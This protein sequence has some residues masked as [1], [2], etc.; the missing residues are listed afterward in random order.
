YIRQSRAASVA[1]NMTFSVPEVADLRSRL[2]TIGTLGEFSTV[3]FNLVGLL[4]EPRIVKA[5]VVNG[6][7]FE[8]MGLRPVLGRLLNALDDGPKAAPVVVLTY[9]FWNDT[10]K[11]D[12]RVIGKVV[13]LG[14]GPATIVGVLEPSVPYPTD[15]ELIANVVASPHHLGA[16]MV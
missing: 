14:P 8:V 6:S 2:T 1:G 12:P 10:V 11:G 15:T 7:F 3:D 16:T 5:G 4:D 9:R 13:R